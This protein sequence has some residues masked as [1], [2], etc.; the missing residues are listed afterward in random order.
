MS[1]LSR[2]LYI[3]LAGLVMLG[4]FWPL[5]S[6]ALAQWDPA[7][8]DAE[9]QAIAYST[10]EPSDAVASLQRAIDGGTAVLQFEAQGGYLRSV[11]KTLH[12]PVNSQGLVFSRTSFLR[13][14]ISP[15]RPRAVYFNNS[16]YV[17][18]VPGGQVLEIASI[19][20]MLGPIFYT[21]AQRP[22]A[23][24]RFVRQTGAC[25]QCHDSPS[26]SAGVPGL[27]MKSVHADS[28]GE[29]IASAGE[30]VTSDQSPMKER[31]GGWYVTGR[32]GAQAHMGSALGAQVE[33][34]RYLVS[35]SD[36]VA[37][38]VLA[39]QSH[40][41]NLLTRVG[42][43]V[44]MALYFD[45]QRN[46]DLGR[47]IDAVPDTTARLVEN[48]TEPLV[49]AML[50]VDEAPLAE[51]ISGTSGFAKTFATQGPRDGRG[52]SLF[53]LDLTRRLLRYPCS[54]VIYSESFDALPVL[55]KNYIYRR[56]WAVLNSEDTSEGFAHLSRSDRTAIRE[57]LLATKRD[58]AA[59]RAIHASR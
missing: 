29:P 13:E 30:Y 57:I 49:R 53:E 47:A 2:H 59:S 12:V 42:Y 8:S 11:L 32:L 35:H 34:M 31:W 39:H 46:R 51:R 21:L 5:A 1:H 58:F 10:T 27:I 19:D 17:T 38:T 48:V 40:V 4:V 50:F 41:Q 9:N 24:P 36:V 23:H 43:R 54:Y 20:P 14:L 18:W 45:R 55:A 56:L 37:L 33:T 22:R 7:T 3:G 16:T 6:R 44:R 25:L 28:N 15:T 26:V 52:R